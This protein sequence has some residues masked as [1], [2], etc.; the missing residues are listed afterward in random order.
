M[1]E[2]H[3]G[4]IRGRL[5]DTYDIMWV[6]NSVVQLLCLSLGPEPVPLHKTL[7]LSPSAGV[8]VATDV[9]PYALS[10]SPDPV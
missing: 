4:R 1:N 6:L 5:A 3:V 2:Q 9:L 8:D 7:L 10:P